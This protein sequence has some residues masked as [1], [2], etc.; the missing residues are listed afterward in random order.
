[1][2]T[3][4]TPNPGYNISNGSDKCGGEGGGCGKDEGGADIVAEEEVVVVVAIF[5][6]GEIS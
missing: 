2:F 1:M 5:A 6:E 3:A 4:T